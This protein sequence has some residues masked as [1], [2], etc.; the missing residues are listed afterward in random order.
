DAVLERLRGALSVA[1]GAHTTPGS[2]RAI[3]QRFALTD[4]PLAVR[5]AAGVA[6]VAFVNAPPCTPPAWDA[7]IDTTAAGS[8]VVHVADRRLGAG[9]TYAVVVDVPSPMVVSGRAYRLADVDPR[10][11]TVLVRPVPGAPGARPAFTEALGAAL[12]LADL[13]EPMRACVE[14]ALRR[15]VVQRLLDATD[16]ERLAAGEAKLRDL[17][18]AALVRAIDALGVVIRD[19][20]GERGEL[21][22]RAPIAAASAPA[23]ARVLGLADLAESAGAGTPFD[24]QTALYRIGRSLPL[25]AREQL[26]PVA[27][28]LGFSARGWRELDEAG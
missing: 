26:A 24:A 23:V 15:A 25:A 14:L 8:P 5:V 4:P 22:P 7:V 11:V 20:G 18:S 19:S 2:A 16:R 9:G 6:A 17:A 3:L 21:G 13:P 1:V 10:G 12:K 27:W 28:R